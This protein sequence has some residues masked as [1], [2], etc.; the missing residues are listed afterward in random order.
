LARRV[1]HAVRKG[2]KRVEF[3]LTEEQTLIQDSA[4]QM[5]ERDI[6][7][8]LDAHPT[9]K[10]LPKA[11]MRQ[12][13][14]ITTRQGLAAPRIPAS[15][16]GGGMKMLDYGLIF[17]QLPAWFAVSVMAHEVTAS[18]IYAESNPEQ[19]ERF[20]PDLFSGRKIAGTATS[21]PGAGSDPRGL[22]TRMDVDGDTAIVNGRKIWISN[23]SV[24]DI[25]AVTC[26][27]GV[28]DKGRNTLKRIVVEPEVSNV[29][30]REIETVGLQQGHLSEAVFEDCEVSAENILSSGGDAAK[31]LTVTWNG[32]RP[33]V[34]LAAAGLT[35]RAFDLAVEY[36][37]VREQFG[38]PIA[39][40]QLVQRNLA[41][42]ETAIMSSRLL[43]YYALDMMDR[44]QRENG[45]AAMAKRYATKACENAI[46]LAMQ[47]H[48]GMG[49][50]REAGLERLWRDVRMLSVPDGTDD[51]LTLIQGR[52]ITGLAAFR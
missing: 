34:G 43:C 24:A 11:A 15:E 29:E 52:E 26:I 36:S 13:Y 51:I 23:G 44:G 7:P 22:T 6:Q 45:A 8:I 5:V 3:Q 14:E 46:S 37:G 41:D 39:G 2:L 31:M 20:M 38:K 30:I 47:V 21:E 10:S 42:I 16:G 49:I 33:L 1:D 25:I 9:D 27:D 17:E 19:R 12:L 40:H 18:R 50:T 48:G 32:N 28:D 35:Q 4:I